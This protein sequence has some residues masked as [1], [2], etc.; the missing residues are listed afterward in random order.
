MVFMA[1]LVHACDFR[2]VEDGVGAVLVVVGR[3]F[4]LQ[5]KQRNI[6]ETAD[7]SSS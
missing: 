5:E 6:T 4:S 1:H 7:V 3:H 2:D